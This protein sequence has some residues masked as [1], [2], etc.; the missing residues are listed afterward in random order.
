MADGEDK[1]YVAYKA[2][3]F[4]SAIHDFFFG[5]NA[6]PP[7]WTLKLRDGGRDQYTQ[8]PFPRVSVK[9]RLL[10]RLNLT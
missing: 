6:I 7:S 4:C 5:H 9:K 2:S 10:C 3:V 1:L 8:E